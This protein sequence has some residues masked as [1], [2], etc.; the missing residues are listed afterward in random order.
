MQA[1]TT[2]ARQKLVDLAQAME[3][4]VAPQSAASRLLKLPHEVAEGASGTGFEPDATLG[5]V[6]LHATETMPLD[7]GEPPRTKST[8]VA[9]TLSAGIQDITNAMVDDFVTMRMILRP[10][11]HGFKRIIFA[12]ATPRQN[13]SWGGLGWGRG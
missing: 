1:A 6:E 7:G 9:E 13:P 4:R 3:I 10:V 8:M 2:K 5:G 12:C 11:R